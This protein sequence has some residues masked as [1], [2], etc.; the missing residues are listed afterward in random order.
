MLYFEK[1]VWL[2]EILCNSLVKTL[3]LRIREIHGIC[4]WLNAIFENAWES[5]DGDVV[6]PQIHR[7][8]WFLQSLREVGVASRDFAK[9]PSR[10]FIARCGYNWSSPALACAL[11]NSTRSLGR[12]LYGEY[13]YS[14]DVCFLF[15]RCEFSCSQIEPMTNQWNSMQNLCTNQLNSMKKSMNTL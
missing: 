11:A 8:T 1:S 12:Q 5:K 6:F 10:R 3:V 15:S 4:N 14:N 2:C 9:E 7:N 13:K